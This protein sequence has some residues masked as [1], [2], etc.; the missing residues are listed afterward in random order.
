[1]NVNIIFATRISSAIKGSQYT[2]KQIAI[3]L[4]ISEGNITNW[5]NGDN[6]PSIETLCKLAILLDEKIDYLVGIEDEVG[7]RSK[8]INIKNFSTQ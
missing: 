1:M 7:N 2:Q 5:K 4:G 3:L 8:S 6:L